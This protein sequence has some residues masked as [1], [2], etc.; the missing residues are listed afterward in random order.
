VWCEDEAGPYQ[1]KPY[2]GAS[3][4]VNGHPLQQPH[5][6]GR[7]GTAKLLT[8]FHP[9]DGQVFVKGVRR[10]T[11]VILHAWLSEQLLTILAA[12][13]PLVQ[14]PAYLDRLCWEIW[15]DGLLHTVTWPLQLPRLRLLL[16]MD[17]L[18]G[19]KN[20]KWLI[21]CF[22]H[23]ILPLYTPLGGSWLNM[24]ESVQRLFK[25][26]AIDGQYPTSPHQI[27]LAL[28]AVARHWNAHPTPF[29][30][31]GKR[32]AHRDRAAFKRHRLAASGA[33]TIRPSRRRILSRS[34]WQPTH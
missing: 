28:E 14:R 26:R 31:A 13:P 32:K 22:Q 8:L 4:A 29:V 30:W 3:W 5:E 1:T 17:N 15:R 19:H 20:P 9:S 10:T 16:I 12:L 34:A 24:A 23:G 27:I 21:W 7:E 6:Y 11:N 18:V 2:P 25:R 33:A